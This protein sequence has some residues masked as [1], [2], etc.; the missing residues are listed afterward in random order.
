MP[1]DTR[2]TDLGIRIGRFTPGPTDGITDVTGVRVAA[3]TIIKGDGALKR[4]VGPIRTG[5]TAILPRGK[6]KAPSPIWAGHY[7]L[8]G[9]G[10][11][12]GTHWI[13][14]AGYMIGPVCI[15]NTHGIGAVH[16]GASRWMTQHYADFDVQVRAVLGPDHDPF[17]E[18]GAFLDTLFTRLLV[19]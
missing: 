5:V 19:P 17:A 12:T 4:G 10:E 16:H 3:T 9:N 18:A 2:A 14:D 1:R 13:D 11:M 6:T 15:T 8:N 7:N